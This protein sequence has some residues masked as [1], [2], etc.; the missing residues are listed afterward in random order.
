MTA[1][2]QQLDSERVTDSEAIVSLVVL[3]GWVMVEVEA[4]PVH[5]GPGL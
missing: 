1:R 3:E 5:A 2:A 4:A